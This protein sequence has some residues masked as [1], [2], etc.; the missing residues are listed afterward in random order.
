[1]VQTPQATT[2]WGRNWK[3]VVAVL[4]VAGVLGIVLT[5]LIVVAGAYFVF[6]LVDRTFKSSGGYQEALAIVRSDPRAV[7]A[8]GTPVDDG[9]FPTGHVDSSGTRGTS[10]LAIPV[11]GPRGSGTLYL[12]AESEMG[13]WR[14]TQ[15]VLKV[16]DTGEEI[17]LLAGRSP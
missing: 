14:F 8:L 17:D 13:V 3:W 10:D 15:L 11:S 6:S 1:V 9:W 5:V 4:C 2:W 12:R 16:K 7:R